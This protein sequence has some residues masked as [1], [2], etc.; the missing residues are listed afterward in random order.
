MLGP[1]APPRTAAWQWDNM[2]SRARPA[3]CARDA[4]NSLRRHVGVWSGHRSPGNSSDTSLAIQTRM[5]S[6]RPRTW[7]TSAWDS[8][9]T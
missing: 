9:H 2:P 3:V 4:P 8:S 7:S 6:E 5:P 1:Q